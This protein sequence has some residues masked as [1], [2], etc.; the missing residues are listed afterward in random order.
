MEQ[1]AVAPESV[2]AEKPK[3]PVPMRECAITKEDLDSAP[4]VDKDKVAEFFEVASQ[5]VFD[6]YETLSAFARE[7]GI[8]VEVPHFVLV[9]PAGCGKSSLLETIVGHPVVNLPDQPCLLL[10]FSSF[11][12][13]FCLVHEKLFKT[14]PKQM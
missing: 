3:T 4:E 2:A 14:T 1:S 10:F 5:D 12:S 11:P 13:H 7:A 8:V 6:A 9:G